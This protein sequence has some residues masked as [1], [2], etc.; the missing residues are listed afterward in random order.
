LIVNAFRDIAPAKRTSA[1][2]PN[3]MLTYSK[4]RN[5]ALVTTTQLYVAL[6]QIETG[7]ITALDF[8]NELHGTVGVL[9]GYGIDKLTVHE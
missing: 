1:A 3:Q 4:N 5:H 6:D 8:L 2:F 7:A 9:K